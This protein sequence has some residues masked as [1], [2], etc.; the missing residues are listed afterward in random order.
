MYVLCS[1]GPVAFCGVALLLCSSYVKK[2]PKGSRCHAQS[3]SY[4]TRHFLDYSLL[5]DIPQVA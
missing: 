3:Q 2:K 1:Q 4:S 5:K